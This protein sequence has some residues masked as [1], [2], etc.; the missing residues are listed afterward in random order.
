MLRA[1]I[2]N[3]RIYKSRGDEGDTSPKLK[4]SNSQVAYLHDSNPSS[5]YSAVHCHFIALRYFCFLLFCCHLRHFMPIYLGYLLWSV[6]LHI[7]L[8]ILESYL[9]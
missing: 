3:L 8:K 1:L 2:A 9:A 6:F 5:F 7:F 4:L